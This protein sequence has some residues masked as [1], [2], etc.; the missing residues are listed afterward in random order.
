MPGVY[1]EDDSKMEYP[2][3]GFIQS[4][5]K[6]SKVGRDE[7][8]IGTGKSQTRLK[9]HKLQ[10]RLWESSTKKAVALRVMPQ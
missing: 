7:K 3:N 1:Q 8:L 6:I 5:H 10:L 2:E 9:V 4:V